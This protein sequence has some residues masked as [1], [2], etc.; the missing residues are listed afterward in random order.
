M[1]FAI[2]FMGMLN[3]VDTLP[4]G[5][6]KL[7][8][9]TMFHEQV[10]RYPEVAPSFPGGEEAMAKFILK[11]LH[12]PTREDVEQPY[13]A[14][15]FPVFFIDTTGKIAK[16]RFGNNKNPTTLLDSAMQNVIIKM[17]KWK[18]GTCNG[19]AVPVLFMLPVRL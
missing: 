14:S 6:C 8:E 17:P 5:F 4:G 16:W 3:R 10:V 1:L 2:L 7:E 9:D 12:I 15:S 13:Y 19:V 11:N 18:P